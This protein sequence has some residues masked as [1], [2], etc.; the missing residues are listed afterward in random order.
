MERP[1]RGTPP[2]PPPRGGARKAASRH[3]PGKTLAGAGL[4][5]PGALAGACLL[6]GALAGGPAG[7]DTGTLETLKQMSIED[8][9]SLEVSIASGRP[10]RFSSTPAAVFV[11]TAED[12]RRAGVTTLPELLRMVPGVQVARANTLD[13][14]VSIRGFNGQ[15]ANKLLVLV[16]GRS[17]YSPLFSGVLWETQNIVLQDVERIEV[18]RGPGASTWGANAV[19]GV[20]NIITKNARDTQ[21]GLGTVGLGTQE[22]VFANA[23]Y[24]CA[25][26]S[27]LSVRGFAKYFMRDAQ[28]LPNGADA[29]DNWWG[30]RGG[31]RLDW[32]VSTDD[33]VTLLGDGYANRNSTQAQQVQLTP[34]YV[35]TQQG[36]TTVFGS[37]LLARWNHVFSE[38]SDM[39][40]QVYYDYTDRDAFLV[41]HLR[42]HTVDFDYQQRN[43]WIPRNA[44]TWGAGYRLYLEKTTPGRA[45]FV[46][47]DRAMNLFSIFALDDITLAVD[48]LRLL[49]GSK[50]EHN[51]F[52]G[53]EVQPNARLMWT[54]GARYTVWTSFARA[55]REPS[56]VENDSITDL[57]VRPPAEPGAPPVVVRTLGNKDERAE[58]LLAYEL[59]VRTRLHDRLSVDVASFFNS[60][61]DLTSFTPGTVFLEPTPLP[62]HLVQPQVASNS[63]S[64]RTAGA[65]VALNLQ[66]LDR[67]RLA[68]TYSYLHIS[69]RNLNAPF[70]VAENNPQHQASLRS[71]LDLPFG[72]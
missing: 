56:R 72:F 32:D 7:A 9:A 62:A 10:E 40:M 46:P 35:L 25:P 4:G 39:K 28:D 58:V 12:I 59:G 38:R 11:I 52:T 6:C 30:A 63:G 68:A 64:G 60:Y 23:R 55:V 57:A 21:G 41:L 24:R 37:S 1:R 18:V 65:E 3:G 31:F 51:V 22:R 47:A 15:F 8:L 34:P 5:L 45:A 36:H 19:N 17:V 13:W 66:P 14:A 16:D 29:F 61:S 49:V 50:L 67:W 20:I 2:P 42:R 48:R 53:F 27:R 71:G 33:R 70:L 54:P 44:I 26:T 69:L 43:A